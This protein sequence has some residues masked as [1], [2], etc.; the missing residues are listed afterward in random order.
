MFEMELSVFI[1]SFSNAPI[2]CVG[3][4][5]ALGRG[6]L[7]PSCCLP[8]AAS[9]RA[10]LAACSLELVERIPV[11]K[12]SSKNKVGVSLSPAMRFLPHTPGG[13]SGRLKPARC[14]VHGLPAL[15]RRRFRVTGAQA[16]SPG[17]GG[18]PFASHPDQ[19]ETRSR[20]GLSG[21]F[22]VS[23]PRWQ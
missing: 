12:S 20:R 22:S 5:S 7:R 16:A 23:L 19:E 1:R 6:L 8:A 10:V 9:R 17:K 3:F 15:T 13:C 4:A 2:G 21:A 11:S 18:N 14:A